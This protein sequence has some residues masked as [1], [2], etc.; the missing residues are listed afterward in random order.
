MNERA[1]LLLSLAD[2]EL[3]L[4]WRNSEWTGIAPFLEEDVA[5]SSIAQNEIGHARAL[6]ELA[7]REL[8]TDADALAF[9]RPLEEYRSAP[10]VELRRLEWAR[11]IARHWLYETADAIR[12]DALK[13]SDDEELAGIA[14]KIDREEVYHRIH[15]EMWID[16][17]LGTDE[18]RGRLDEAL[19]ELWP[20]ALGVL[21]DALRPEL[22]RRVEAKLGRAMREV[23]PIARG[24]HEAELAELH[25]E[26]TMVRR[27]APAGA[28]W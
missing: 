22:V 14:A 16:R 10:L 8:G 3:I 27:S 18:G 2:D 25:E 21:D 26:M 9:D 20:Y 13:E 28:R 6:Y 19:D 15:A 12:L 11:T 23:A 1:Q 24:R 5:F 17:L 7:A 4:G